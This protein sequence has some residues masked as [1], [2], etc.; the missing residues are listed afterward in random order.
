MTRRRGGRTRSK[1]WGGKH[2][3]CREVAHLL[4]DHLQQALR[5]ESLRQVE[6]HLQTCGACR[7]D[8]ALWQQLGSLPTAEPGPLLRHRFDTMLESFQQGRREAEARRHIGAAP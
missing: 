3:D 6:A 1:V 7:E 2:M 4:P 8:V 5:G